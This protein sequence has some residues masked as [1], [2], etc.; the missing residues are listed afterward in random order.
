[1]S[2]VHPESTSRRNKSIASYAAL[3]LLAMALWGCN[4]E[5][6]DSRVPMSVAVA[7][8]SFKQGDDIP[9]QFTCKGANISPELSWHS[10]PPGTKSVALTVTDSHSIFGPYVHWI[11]YNQPSESSRLA[12]DLPK[13]E[14]LPGGAKQGINSNGAVGYAGPCPSGTS[15]H[16][17]VFTVYAL[18]TLLAPAT[19]VDR[20]QLMKAMKG[21]IL[22]AGQLMG[23]Y[24]G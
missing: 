1:M 18:D 21:H 4:R 23:R 19:P 13:E 7:S 14:S 17:Y 8:D 15:P 22:A 16:R 9:Q 24:H 3:S 20:P 6:I 12:E 10:L 5:S 11:L 2:L